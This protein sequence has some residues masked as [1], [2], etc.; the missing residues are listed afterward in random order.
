MN[1]A[2]NQVVVSLDG[3]VSEAE[4]ARVDSV[5]E[6]FGDAVRVERVAGAFSTT[7]SGGQAIYGGGGR[8]SLGFNMRSGSTY[9]RR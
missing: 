1:R 3:T 5:V 8:C 4:A 6:R 9:C 2:A 7:V